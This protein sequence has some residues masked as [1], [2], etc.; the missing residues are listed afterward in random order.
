M[1]RFS[2]EQILP[3]TP[4]QLFDL[5]ADIESYPEFLP[6][7][8]G[9]KILARESEKILIAELVINFKA[10]IERYT[11]RVTLDRAALEITV[12]LVQG[13]FK[14]LYNGWKFTSVREGV[15]VEFDIDFELRSA[16]LQAVAT[17]AFNKAYQQMID[18]FANRAQ[19]IY[20]AKTSL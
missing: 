7:C 13:P 15:R 1:P 20:K 6:W 19:K 17:P 3:Y 16:L 18:A 10:F 12:E 8:K 4:D 2:H 5:A 14:H 9:A 11:S